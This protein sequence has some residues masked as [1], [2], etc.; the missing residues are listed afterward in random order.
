MDRKTLTRIENIAI[1]DVAADAVGAVTDAVAGVMDTLLEKRDDTRTYLDEI[2]D[3][4]VE[5]LGKLEDVTQEKYDEVVK[6]VIADHTA[7]KKI[8]V[9]Q[10][11]EL[12]AR[13]RDGY[14]A[15]RQ[16]IHEHTAANESP[17]ST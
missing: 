2:K 8:S 7:A 15:V 10:A 17:T 14:E 4:I 5:R 9:D 3:R 12:E 13:L 16:T 1:E 11:K 6:A